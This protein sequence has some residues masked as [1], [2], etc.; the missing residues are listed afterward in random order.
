[1]SAFDKLAE[2]LDVEIEIETPAEIVPAKLNNKIISNEA[3]VEKDYDYARANLIDLIDK[4][5]EIINGAM[6]V[7]F[8]T[9][10]PRAFEVALN[11]VKNI[12]DVTEKLMDI[13]KK[14]KDINNSD[15]TSTQ[16]AQN[17][18]NNIYMTG[19]TADLMSLIRS[20]QKKL[21]DNKKSK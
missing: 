19:T 15:D 14:K 13:H 12:A 16:T 18:Q 17:I 20:N 11:G 9:D 10:H 21:L 5:Q 7:A 8:A 3:D 2:T 4:G 1:M 6:E